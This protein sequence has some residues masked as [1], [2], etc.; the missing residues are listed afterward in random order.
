MLK[1]LCPIC[2]KELVVTGQERLETLDEHVCNPNGE[3]C[4]KDKYECINETCSAY[5]RIMWGEDGDLYWKNG[6]S[7]KEYFNFIDGNEAPFGSFSRRMNVEIYKKDENFLLCT[8]FER[9]NYVKYLYKSNEDGDIL[10]RKWKFELI[11]KDGTIY[12]SGLRMLV[13]SIKKFHRNLFEKTIDEE[14]FKEEYLVLQDW[15]KKDW[16]RRLSCWWA[17]TYCLIAG[18]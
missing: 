16:W 7:R 10:N 6:W 3:I 5:N 8:I 2:K 1:M 15:Q 11:T 4:L 13:Y 14:K 17:R 12:I 18:V 9:K